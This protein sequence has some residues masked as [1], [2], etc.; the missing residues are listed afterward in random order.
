MRRIKTLIILLLAFTVWTNAQEVQVQLDE[1]LSSYR[2]EDLENARFALQEA[3]NEINKAV[4]NEILKALPTD[5]NG[6]NRVEEA[7]DVTGISM[8]FAS[9]FVHRSYK[10]ENRQASIDILADSPMLMGVNT[11]LS[12]SA[13]MSSDDNQKRIKLSG[14]KALLTRNED[15]SGQVSYDIQVPLSTSLLTFECTGFSEE[16]DVLEMANRIP[17]DRIAELSD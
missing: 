14:Y 9:L 12:M 1:A 17:V 16:S 5:M 13:F 15:E 4:G 3:L 6:M 8:G 7:D 10:D 11:I 2:S